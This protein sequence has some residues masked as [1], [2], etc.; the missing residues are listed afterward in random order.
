MAESFQPDV[1]PGDPAVAGLCLHCG[2]CCNGVL[3]K[4][5]EL[6]AGDKVA[7]LQFLGLP[8]SGPRPGGRQRPAGAGVLRFAQPCAALRG[9]LCRVYP[10]RPARCRDFECGLLKAVQAGRTEVNAALRIIRSVRGKADVVLGLLRE[11]GDGD[12]HLALS[13]RFQRTRR[14]FEKGVADDDRVETFS[15]LTLAVHDLNLMLRDKFYPGDSGGG[16]VRQR[17][18]RQPFPK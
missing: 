12:E 1:T 17:E 18:S 14:R 4:D 5:V 9:C 6:Q 16:A 15:R 8:I 13:L 11:L 10:D 7:R 3:F 2:L